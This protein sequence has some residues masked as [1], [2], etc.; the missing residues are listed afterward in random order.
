MTN[1]RARAVISTEALVRNLDLVHG[2]AG[3]D[4]MAVV[5][6]DAYGHGVAELAPLLR[7]HGITW[8]G[9]ALPSEA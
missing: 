1:F 9:V 5:K 2:I 6:A 4:V 8:L 3:V 7:D